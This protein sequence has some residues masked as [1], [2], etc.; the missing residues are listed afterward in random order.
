[1]AFPANSVLAMYRTS[2]EIPLSSNHLQSLKMIQGGYYK[3]SLHEHFHSD[4]KLLVTYNSFVLHPLR[5]LLHSSVSDFYH[6]GHVLHQ[7]TSVI[8]QELCHRLY[9]SQ[10]TNQVFGLFL[11]ARKLREVPASRWE[12]LSGTQGYQGHLQS[13]LNGSW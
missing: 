9:N 4:N 2:T 12:G 3:L 7:C 8:H 1:M 13:A 10:L 5:P 11:E 6:I